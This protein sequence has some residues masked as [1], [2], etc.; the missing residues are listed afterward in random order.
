MWRDLQKKRSGMIPV[1]SREGGATEGMASMTI[2]GPGGIQW[3]LRL[4]PSIVSM[5]GSLR[6][7]RYELDASMFTDFGGMWS[8]DC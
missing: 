1:S 6:K 2:E 7:L 4:Y 3:I 5:A 8:V